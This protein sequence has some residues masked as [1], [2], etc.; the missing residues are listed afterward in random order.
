MVYV[1][2]VIFDENDKP[3]HVLF[4]IIMEELAVGDKIG[5]EVNA[6]SMPDDFTASNV[7]RYEVFAYPMQ[8]QF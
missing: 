2:V 1:A 6:L 7:T 8:M 3:A 5:F 4:T